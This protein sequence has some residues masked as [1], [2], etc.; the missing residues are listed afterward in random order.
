MGDELQVLLFA[1]ASIGFIHTITGPDHYLPFIV[2][3]KARRWSMVRTTVITLACGVA[4]VLS[5]VVLGIVGIGLGWAVTKVEGFESF[6]GDLAGWALLAFGLAYTIWGLRRAI[7]S[8]PHSHVHEHDHG[9]QHEHSHTHFHDHSHVHATE[10]GTITP[11][12]LFIIFVLGPC[13]PL[14]PLL[15]Y[16]AAQASI[17]G[18]VLVTS[19]FG[20]VTIGTMLG[21][22]LLVTR[23]IELIP[24]RR[25]ERYAHAMAGATVLLCGVAI[26]FLGL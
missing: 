25:L 3:A 26:Q 1:A 24:A 2:L 7:R 22:V 11:W 12:V 18:L 5:S 19:V 8:R 21:A 16:P 23:G 14:I 10:S 4:H 13:E 9:V 15:M 17:T 6:R 20:L